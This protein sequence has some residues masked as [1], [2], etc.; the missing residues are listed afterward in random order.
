[1]DRYDI[2]VTGVGGQ[3]I[4]FISE[5]IGE[6]ALQEGLNTRVAEV[7]GMAQRGGSVTCNVRI[8]DKVYSPMV[9]EGSA[10]LVIAL[11]PLEALRLIRFLNED[12][13]V[14]M[15][16]AAVVPPSAWI[17]AKKYPDM[18][19][20]LNEIRR[21]SKKVITV[22]AWRLAGITG[23]QATQNSVLLGVI[24][25]LTAFPVSREAIKTTIARRAPQRYVAANL[26][27]FEL[28][29]QEFRKTSNQVP[30]GT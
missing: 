13:M 23:V 22:D 14:I 8:G 29:Q 21:F 1:M 11:E 4:I 27:A 17:Q 15:N 9:M 12:T 10:D 20:I 24:S 5:V 25:E 16:N 18:S 6:A 26:A 19:V 7:H 3:G 30:P 28:G 2:M